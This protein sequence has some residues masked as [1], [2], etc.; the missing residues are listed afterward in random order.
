VKRHSCYLHV[1]LTGALVCA[2][3]GMAVQTPAWAQTGIQFTAQEPASETKTLAVVA[4]N[5]YDELVADIG[6]SGSLADRPETGQ[7]VDGMIALFTQGKGLAGV[8]KSKPWGVVVQTDGAQILPIG[9]LPVTSLDELVS[10]G[11]PFGVQVEE[12]SEGIKVISLPNQQT[13]YAKAKGGWAFLSITPD[14][15]A[16]APSNPSALLSKLIAD[17]DF[18]AR[19]S[20]TNAPEM[21]KQQAI[22]AMQAGLKQGLEQQSG[23]D[24][25]AFEARKQVAE[26]QMEQIVQMIDEM[27]EVT[28]GW[29]L[30]SEQQRAYADFVYTFLPDSKMAKQMNSYGQPQTNFAGFYQSSAAVSMSFASKTDPSLIQADI[31]QIRAGMQTMRQQVMK[32]LDEETEFPDDASRDAVKEAMGD[33]I[34][35]LESTIASGQMDGGASLQLEPEKL[36]IVAG[37]LVKDPSKIESALKKL[38]AAAEKDPEF[39]GVQWNAATHGD[40]NFHTLEV[41]MPAN[42][43]DVK[44]NVRKLLG[45]KVNV[46]IGIGPEA[47]YVAAGKDYLEVV[48]QAIDASKADPNKSVPPFEVSA[49]LG[50]IMATFAAN[51]EN[52]K[53][54][55]LAQ[56]IAD[57]LQGEA[58]GRDHIRMVGQFIPNG[59][60]YRVEAEEGV[61]R[62]IGKAAAEAQE[63]AQQ[64]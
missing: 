6:F 13:I 40:V 59:L 44:P 60:R 23:E 42:K 49:S 8:D 22:T 5:S 14:A 58:Q 3:L 16:S 35:A 47:I 46:A 43:G 4:V 63:Q 9:C 21:Y 7:M 12:N 54:R 56:S 29:A 17:Y 1:V 18:A 24:D 15:L 30:D 28:V 57:M 26:A 50:P 38:A 62:A 39:P 25:A 2:S 37:M 64:P 55:Q 48:N 32:A 51:E 45:D 31:E 36:T 34:D 41:P 20:M 27:D 11:Q 61:L 33:F 53:Q 10:L 19:I 52:A